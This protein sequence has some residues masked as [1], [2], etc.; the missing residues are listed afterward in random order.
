MG[1]AENGV[2]DFFAQT[3]Q[4][5]DVVVGILCTAMALDGTV[6]TVTGEVEIGEKI[7]ADDIVGIQNHHVIIVGF[8]RFRLGG[9]TFCLL[10]GKL[11]CFGL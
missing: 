10:N 1:L 7:I 2:V 5:G 11:E 3:I 4:Y 9:F 8:G 6:A